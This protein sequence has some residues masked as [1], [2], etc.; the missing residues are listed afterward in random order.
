MTQGIRLASAAGLILRVLTGPVQAAAPLELS[1]SDFHARPIGPRGPQPGE[2]LLAAD[3]RR[4][5][6]TG[7]MAAQERPQPG[8]FFL[9]PH[10]LLMSQ[11]ADGEADD[12]P[13]SAVVVLMPAAESDLVLPHT[14]GLLRL[15]GTLS[16]GRREGPDGRV[17][18]VWLQLE[19]RA[20]DPVALA[21]SLPA[22]PDPPTSPVTP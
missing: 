14:R 1:F 2:R 22:A 10:P 13:A 20:V 11:H 12:L 5:Q 8:R 18:W 19:P 4:V 21:P 6:I 16:L 7:Y 17:G 9:V 15:T 3:G